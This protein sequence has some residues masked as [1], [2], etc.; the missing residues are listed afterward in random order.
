MNTNSSS[1]GSDAELR[2]LPQPSSSSS[3]PS[4]PSSPPIA[5]NILLETDKAPNPSPA[6]DSINDSS[7]HTVVL[8]LPTP[9]P[10]RNKFAKPR[11]NKSVLGDLRY[12]I[13]KRAGIISE[14]PAHINEKMLNAPGATPHSQVDPFHEESPIINV[15]SA[16]NLTEIGEIEHKNRSFQ[17]VVKDVRAKT[18][19]LR[20]TKNRDLNLPDLVR[21]QDCHFSSILT[22][23]FQIKTDI[24]TRTVLSK[25]KLEPKKQAMFAKHFDT[26]ESKAIISDMFWF[27][28]VAFFEPSKLEEGEMLTHFEK[29]A[30]TTTKF[31]WN[32]K[33]EERDQFFDMY[34]YAVSYSIVRALKKH[35]KGSKDY[36]TREWQLRVFELMSELFTGIRL[37]K[38][39]L[40]QKCIQMF[41]QKKKDFITQLKKHKKKMQEGKVGI[42]HNEEAPRGYYSSDDNDDLFENF[43]D[44]SDQHITDAQAMESSDNILHNDEDEVIEEQDPDLQLFVQ[45]LSNP[46]LVDTISKEG[47]LGI[48]MKRDYVREQAKKILKPV[49]KLTRAQKQLQLHLAKTGQDT[50]SS[51]RGFQSYYNQEVSTPKSMYSGLATPVPK[52][53]LGMFGGG[54]RKPKS[55]FDDDFELK[56]DSPRFRTTSLSKFLQKIFQKMKIGGVLGSE[57]E[58]GYWNTFGMSPLIGSAIKEPVEFYYAGQARLMKK[59]LTV[60]NAHF[61]GS[62]TN[63]E[64]KTKLIKN[65][66]DTWVKPKSKQHFANE[67]KSQAVNSIHH[68]VKSQLINEAL[69]TIKVRAYEEQIEIKE[70]TQE[71]LQDE[72]LVSNLSKVIVK[73]HQGKV[74][75]H[76]LYEKFD[77]SAFKGTQLAEYAHNNVEAVQ[78]KFKNLEKMDM[79]NIQKRGKSSKIVVP[80]VN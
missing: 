1:P 15:T 4:S 19:M 43:D 63:P 20:L 17:D 53:E 13:Q 57:N 38:N 28:F 23:P 58:K 62:E 36:F 25:M 79:R 7:S 51:G 40:K 78:K 39:L 31:F 54:K 21:V 64:M 59:N 46:G 47:F 74:H 22:P 44:D 41:P 24:L 12:V 26:E 5:N 66:K 72:Q 9:P 32:V 8:D 60:H 71:V 50:N 42:E 16:F 37:R 11:S 55:F 10:P 2:A 18:N 80:I 6:N 33:R 35:F 29:M 34:H 69:D 77:A 45:Q 14:L 61:F 67:L 73:Q 76:R 48:D 49:K 56:K 70:E 75:N 30:A 27:S 68:R 3:S 52:S 65:Y